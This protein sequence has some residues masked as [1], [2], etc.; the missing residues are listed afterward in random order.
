M[1]DDQ[2]HERFSG[3]GASRGD[4]GDVPSIDA[5]WA[6]GRR[7]QRRRLTA[8]VAS[9][10]V[11]LIAAG[12]AV[13]SVPGEKEGVQRVATQ[14]EGTQDVCRALRRQVLPANDHQ[15]FPLPRPAGALPEDPADAS[16]VPS[17][18]DESASVGSMDLS[19]IPRSLEAVVADF[20]PT[21]TVSFDMVVD[22]ETAEARADAIRGQQ[23]VRS[24][25][26][27]SR[28][29]ALAVVRKAY[30]DQPDVV[31]NVIAN[32]LP[33]SL[34]VEV[35][36]DSLDRLEDLWAAEPGV[37]SVTDGT[38]GLRFMLSQA[39][40]LED[41][42]IDTGLD[43]LRADLA[44]IDEP[45]ARALVQKID[46]TTAT[47]NELR[48]LDR[49]SLSGAATFRIVTG[50]KAAMAECSPPPQPH[51]N[52][53][54]TTSS[55]VEVAPLTGTAAACAAIDRAFAP[56]PRTDA[57]TLRTVLSMIDASEVKI[58]LDSALDGA[59]QQAF[60]DTV[61]ARRDVEV[62]HAR[63]TQEAQDEFRD[64]LNGAIPPAGEDPEGDE[65]VDSVV[66]GVL[67]VRVAPAGQAAF[68]Q[69]V[70]DQ[71]GDMVAAVSADLG[72][73]GFPLQFMTAGDDP[74]VVSALAEVRADLGRAEL[75]WADDLLALLDEA[76][77]SDTPLTVD[78]AR[79]AAI[80]DAASQACSVP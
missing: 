16:V 21:V 12:V 20:D 58:T 23:G 78:P 22:E 3:A 31:D 10:A 69:W 57:P 49:T 32:G 39:A 62:V 46:A 45:W 43:E 80:D 28:E 60:I 48:V 47:P 9:A 79:W 73:L 4:G 24:V 17:I 77:A 38:N 14:P 42:G 56:A 8:A 75:P 2:L 29:E 55:S 70:A 1:N 54:F 5:L 53:E 65:I 44:S 64:N 26:V 59:A 40:V 68:A 27:R 19:G 35:D 74:Y 67:I 61:A 6:A 76:A 66:K 72:Q 30:A 36:P 71:S 41:R 63:T 7:R 13:A 37:A 34:A 18:P 25:A 52:D 11:L 51:P 33:L 50:A 15:E